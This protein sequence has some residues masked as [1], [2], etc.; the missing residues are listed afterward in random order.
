MLFRS[1][2]IDPKAVEGV[3]GQTFRDIVHLT[4]DPND[5]DRF[6][7]FSWGE[8]IYE[9]RNNELHQWH[10]W[11]NSNIESA[12]GYLNYMRCDGG[13][14]DKY[15]NMWFLN[16]NIDNVLKVY[17]R[18]GTWIDYHISGLS[19]I[20]NIEKI[21]ITS[22]DQKWINPLFSSKGYGVYILGE[23]TG[24]LSAN[25]TFDQ[26]FVTEFKYLDSGS[27]ASF[28]SKVKAM[29]EDQNGDIWLGTEAG[30]I[31]ASNPQNVYPFK[32]YW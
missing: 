32:M 9:F 27:E 5:S 4:V 12:N 17:K 2:N 7:A 3:T 18:D 19:Q 10:H 20:N 14:F 13:A 1:I 8:G 26:R 16:S 30:T 31:I 21:L 25:S 11:E 22:R 15:G 23:T 24:E 28:S 29:V 6:F